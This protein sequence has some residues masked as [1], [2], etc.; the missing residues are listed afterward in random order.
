MGRTVRGDRRRREAIGGGAATG[1]CNQARRAHRAPSGAAWAAISR[2]AGRGAWRATVQGRAGGAATLLLLGAA[3]TAAAPTAGVA[4]AIAASWHRR[5]R[6]AGQGSES[7]WCL[8]WAGLVVAPDVQCNA[9]HRADCYLAHTASLLCLAVPTWGSSPQRPP[10]CTLR[11]SQPLHILTDRR[12]LEC[13]APASA[14][15]RAPP[16]SRRPAALRRPCA[17]QQSCM[18]LQAA[19]GPGPSAGTAHAAHAVRSPSLGRHP[20]WR[21]AGYG[22][23][24]TSA[25]GF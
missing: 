13:S 19:T 3:R 8:H 18:H 17:P 6:A 1:L 7:G 21:G 15:S 14:S 16:Q 23:T 20:S 12:Q 25:T 22:G 5:E 2:L 9:G 4:T 10:P 24:R 11:C